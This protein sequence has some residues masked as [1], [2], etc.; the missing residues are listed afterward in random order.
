MIQR[1]QAI[2]HRPGRGRK[3]EAGPADNRAVAV[4]AIDIGRQVT[5]LQAHQ[6]RLGTGF[7]KADFAAQAN[8]VAA[9]DDVHQRGEVLGLD[10][11]CK[12]GTSTQIGQPFAGPRCQLRG[13]QRIGKQIVGGQAVLGQ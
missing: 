13:G 6:R 5:P 12:I 8:R 11:R 7:K 2:H 9:P 10:G 4:Q 3:A 1:H